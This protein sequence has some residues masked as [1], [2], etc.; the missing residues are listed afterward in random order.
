MIFLNR[1]GKYEKFDDS[2][3]Y[4]FF[5]TSIIVQKFLTDF[6]PRTLVAEVP[7][8]VTHHFC[9]PQKKVM[10]FLTSSKFRAAASI[11]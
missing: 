1:G 8:N 10:Y 2:N 3:Y 9:S 11:V 5:F 7:I 6:Q 4:N